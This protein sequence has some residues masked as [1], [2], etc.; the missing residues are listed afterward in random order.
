MRFMQKIER[1]FSLIELLVVVAIIGLLAALLIPQCAK[2][3]GGYPLGSDIICDG[4][5]GALTLQLTNATGGTLIITNSV[6]YTGINSGGKTSDSQRV[7]L[8]IKPDANNDLFISPAPIQ[9]AS[10]GA[11][12]NFVVTGGITNYAIFGPC[13]GTK[14]LHGV[15]NSTNPATAFVSQRPA[16]INTP[17]V[18]SAAASVGAGAFTNIPISFVDYFHQSN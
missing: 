5:A 9:P 3:Q 10:P 1:G 12:N 16:L 11:T 6:A 2:A 14:L 7:Q 18:V 17:V 13:A 8:T 4:A 15:G